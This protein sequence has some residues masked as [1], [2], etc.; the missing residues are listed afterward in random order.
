MHGDDL[1]SVFVLAA[2]AI[3]TAAY[4]WGRADG[5]QSAMNQMRDEFAAYRETMRVGVE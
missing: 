5:R 3:A 2:F 4:L 1:M